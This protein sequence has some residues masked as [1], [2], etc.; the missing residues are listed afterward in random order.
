MNNEN[1]FDYECGSFFFFFS[2]LY[3]LLYLSYKKYIFLHI[4]SVYFYGD[5]EINPPT[6]VTE[7]NH[8]P[9]IHLL[10]THFQTGL[11]Y[12]P[13]ALVYILLYPLKL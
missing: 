13:Y 5:M 6:P 1:S 8:P 7:P 12:L 2:L 4:L 3:S 9:F 11:T 10:T